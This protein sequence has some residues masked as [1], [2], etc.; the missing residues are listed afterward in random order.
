MELPES[1]P[2]IVERAFQI[3]KG[4]RAANVGAL[5]IQ[6]AEEGYANAAFALGGRAL[7]TQLTRMIFEAR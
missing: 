2:G 7:Y 1:M 5:R 3:A 6:L 4:G